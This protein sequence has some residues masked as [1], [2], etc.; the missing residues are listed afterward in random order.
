MSERPDARY[1]SARARKSWSAPRC[2]PDRTSTSILVA[3]GRML[4]PP[5]AAE[6]GTNRRP[7]FARPVEL[8]VAQRASS[9]QVSAL[10]V[11]QSSSGL[12]TTGV[13]VLSE[14]RA[15][16]SHNPITPLGAEWVTGQPRRAVDAGDVSDASIGGARLLTGTDGSLSMNPWPT[17]STIMSQASHGRSSYEAGSRMVGDRGERSRLPAH[18]GRPPA[19]RETRGRRRRERV[20]WTGL[21]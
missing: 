11:D 21:P 4:Y 12:H 2:L 16:S 3:T 15:R 20:R 5:G 1:R 18:R 8:S 7:D 17:G 19:R 14:A 10:Q 9:S 13:R 6:N